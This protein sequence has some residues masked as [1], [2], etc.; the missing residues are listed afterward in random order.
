[1]V[2][3]SILF[4]GEKYMQSAVFGNFDALLSLSRQMGLEDVIYGLRYKP[5]STSNISSIT[6]SQMLSWTLWL[7][8]TPAVVIGAVATFVLVR[9]KHS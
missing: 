4:A 6:T 7:T 1:M 8:I 3:S 9:R 2:C 5:F